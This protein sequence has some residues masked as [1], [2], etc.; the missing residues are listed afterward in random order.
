MHSHGT[1]PPGSPLRRNL[2][3]EQNSSHCEL[4]DCACGYV[5]YEREQ[6][7]ELIY[8]EEAAAADKR[9]LCCSLLTLVLSIPALIGA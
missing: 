4:E 7:G 8:D 2:L 3:Q 1:I 6:A 9:A 5:E